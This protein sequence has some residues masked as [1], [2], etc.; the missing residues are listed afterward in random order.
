MADA[1]NRV[2]CYRRIPLP[3]YKMSSFITADFPPPG[4]GFVTVIFAVPANPRTADAQVGK[5]FRHHS[6]A[7]V[8]CLR[9]TYFSLLAAAAS[10]CPLPQPLNLFHMVPS[11]DPMK[12]SPL[13]SGE[14]SQNRMVQ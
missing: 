11:V 3:G 4:A 12:F 13:P 6:R 10:L 2:R 8:R 5:L 1:S 9:N 7:N 14:R